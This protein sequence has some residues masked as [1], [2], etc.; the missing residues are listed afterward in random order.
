MEITTPGMGTVGAFYW[1]VAGGD[2]H[3][4]NRDGGNIILECCMV[5]L[6]AWGMEIVGTLHWSVAGWS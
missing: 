4:G 5:E 3:P 1:S 2:R 6:V